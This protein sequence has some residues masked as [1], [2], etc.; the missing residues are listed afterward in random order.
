MITY[1]V[2]QYENTV[3]TELRSF[4]TALHY[5]VDH[6]VRIV[7][8]NLLM[9]LFEFQPWNYEIGFFSLDSSAS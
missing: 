4:S 1:H 5:S 2:L 6:V 8:N 9:K 7:R 3:D